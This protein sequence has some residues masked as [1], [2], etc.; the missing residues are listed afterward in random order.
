V[1]TL[2][3]QVTP[4]GS[5][6]SART[7]NESPLP[8]APR[9]VQIEGKSLTPPP[10]DPPGV[11]RTNVQ[12]G[13]GNLTLHLAC[14]PEVLPDQRAEL[15]LDDIALPAAPRPG[16]TGSLTF[17]AKGMP[18]GTFRLRLRVDGV[19]SLLVDRSE[20]RQPR[21]DESQRVTIA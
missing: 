10:A 1:C 4:T 20:A 19:D 21:F 6:H 2:A 15:I 8:V 13:L 17:T 5:P 9:I 16:P 3:V 7:T 18:A 12:D 14:E 11:S